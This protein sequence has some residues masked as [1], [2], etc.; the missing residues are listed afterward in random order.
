MFPCKRGTGNGEVR[1][2][3][4]SG[5]D[6]ASRCPDGFLFCLPHGDRYSS[7]CKG[8]SGH[9]SRIG[10]AAAGGPTYLAASEDKENSGPTSKISFCRTENSDESEGQESTSTLK[11]GALTPE[12]KGFRAHRL[13]PN[14]ALPLRRG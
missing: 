8:W 13:G 4:D 11:D 14:W 1:G 12:A 9:G 2:S 7:E 10:E 6:G 3:P 5:K